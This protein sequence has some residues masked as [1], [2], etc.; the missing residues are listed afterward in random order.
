[1]WNNHGGGMLL[2]GLVLE[3]DFS[4]EPCTET[5]LTSEWNSCNAL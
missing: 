2:A 3:A 4:R 5:S 1:M